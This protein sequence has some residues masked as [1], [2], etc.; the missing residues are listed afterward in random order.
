MRL[1]LHLD[2][3]HL[4]NCLVQCLYCIDGFTSQAFG[5]RLRQPC[6]IWRHRFGTLRDD[7]VDDVQQLFRAEGLVDVFVESFFHKFV[8]HFLTRR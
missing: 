5:Y 8:A 6:K 3:V 4:V 1:R 2:E 7:L